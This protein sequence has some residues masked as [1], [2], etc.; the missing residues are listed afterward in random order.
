VASQGPHVV[1][2]L[3]DDINRL[4]EESNK[5]NN[6]IDRGYPVDVPGTGELLGAADPAPAGVDLSAEGTQDWAAWGLGGK[7]G[8]NRKAGAAHLIGTVSEVGHGFMD[9]TPGCGTSLH[10]SN[11]APT[12]S[13]PDTHSGL[14][15]NGVGHGYQFDVAADTTERTLRV[16]VSGI[17]GAGCK[18]TASL[19]DGSAPDYVSDSFNGNLAFGWAPVPGGFSGVYTLKY[20]A[21]SAGQH[22]RVTWQLDSEPNR[23]LG[24]ARLQA[25]TVCV[26]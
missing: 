10:W 4:P 23:F 17:E 5:E 2:V 13:E 21:G 16:Y 8:I 26:G 15:L 11:G 9:A 7:A 6:V 20:R 12:A 19:S 14:W 3:V 1:K 22:L 25:A 24:Q 18:L